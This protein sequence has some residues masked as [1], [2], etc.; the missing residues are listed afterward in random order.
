MKFLVALRL[1]SE[2]QGYELC[3]ST[4]LRVKMNCEVREFYGIKK[5]AIV[6]QV[7]KVIFN[8]LISFVNKRIIWK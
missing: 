6:L 2:G 5:P 1:R 8:R 3:P 4:V 7:Y